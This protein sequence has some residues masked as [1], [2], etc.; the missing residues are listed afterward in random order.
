M[1][2]CVAGDLPAGLYGFS[3][4]YRSPVVMGWSP[5]VLIGLLDQVNQGLKFPWQTLFAKSMPIIVSFTSAEV[6]AKRL[7]FV[8]ST[9]FSEGVA[10]PSVCCSWWFKCF[11]TMK[12]AVSMAI[13]G[14]GLGD[15]TAAPRP[16][17]ASHRVSGALRSLA[18]GTVFALVGCAIAPSGPERTAE[19]IQPMFPAP[20]AAARYRFERTLYGAKDVLAEEGNA[21][22]RKFLHREDQD[23]GPGLTSP[24]A[25]AVD[26]GRVF[27]SD[28]AERQINVFDIPGRRFYSIGA[29]GPG[30]LQKP[31]GLSIDR[32][33]QLFVA[34]AG[35]NAILAYDAQGKYLR[36]IGGPQW[37]A[38]LASVTADP[39]GKRLYAIDS[40]EAGK[41][42]PRVR[43]FDPRD[44]RHLFDFGARGSGPGEF[45]TPYDLA[46]GSAGKLY[47][48]DSG[49]P[50]VQTFDRQGKY[51]NSFGTVGRR[52]GQFG[53]PKAI[54]T[55]A[56]G[57]V[58]VVDAL[59]G[60]FQVFDPRGVML[61]SIGG[62]GEDGGPLSYLLPSG[63]AIDEDGSLYF[64]DQGYRKI[65]V[66]RPL[67]DRRVSP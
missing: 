18:A 67:G 54:A 3:T 28:L 13:L 27:V 64:L 35:A 12:A 15:G 55:D 58:Y 56:A 34:D 5:P 20:P 25:L 62:H 8:T 24:H 53:R 19:A 32:A 52:P 30:T 46:V 23:A 48:T 65:D 4:V 47:V 41:G 38:R 31:L 37:F 9:P 16:A 63:I 51:L 39:D 60:N 49:N 66:F 10:I 6:L 1:W 21:A 26:H 42:E 17:P 59:L 36:S 50:R 2:L 29:A 44:G 45:N 11:F 40:G 14:N 7:H 22:L 61:F 57:E 43:V 33:G